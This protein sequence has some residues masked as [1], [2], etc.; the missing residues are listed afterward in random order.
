MD[1]TSTDQG[2]TSVSTG[3]TSTAT[4]TA[5]NSGTPQNQSTSVAGSQPTVNHE[6]NAK[7][8]QS[9]WTKTA[10]EASRLKAELAKERDLR[11]R[12]ENERRQAESRNQGH[13]QPD[14]LVTAL[15]Q[16]PY[17]SGKD[18]VNAV[19]A[20]RNEI[21]QRDQITLAVLKE[22][23]TMKDQLGGLNQ[24]HAQSSFENKINRWIDEGGYPKEAAKLAQALYVAHE[25]D[26]LDQ[27]FPR[28]FKE[29]WD[30]TQR[31]FES[32]RNAKLNAA[33]K[34]PFVPGKGGQTGP[35]KPL[36]FKGNESAKEI[37][38]ALWKSW[39]GTET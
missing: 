39:E 18:A 19:S 33:R 17:L 36:Q 21:R 28:I 5:T 24:T 30:E 10:Q 6:E 15:E 22:L 32:Q 23:K 20:I 13:N 1:N 12:Y 14:E 16:L 27:E 7:R 11:T 8:F 9:Q 38:E 25:G 2:G 37:T 26:D 34:V 29:Y 31:V 4:S 3:E 35:S